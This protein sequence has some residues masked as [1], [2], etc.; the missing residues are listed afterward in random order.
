MAD[1]RLPRLEARAQAE[2]GWE[3]DDWAAILRRRRR[4]DWL[5]AGG[6]VLAAV[7]FPIVRLVLDRSLDLSF[8]VFLAIVLINAWETWQRHRT[9]EGR[10]RWERETGQKVRLGHALREHVSIGRDERD[11]V[12]ARARAINRWAPAHVVGWPLLAVLTL[13]G[14]DADGGQYRDAR[15]VFG[16]GVSLLCAILVFRAATRVRR[17][18]R[19]LA[20]PLPRDDSPAA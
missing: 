19:W 7:L 14:I 18:R 16:V 11:V 13:V 10:V 6:L 12:T 3:P 15:L 17:A 9:E 2:H 1:D 4:L 8:W 5:S 20:D